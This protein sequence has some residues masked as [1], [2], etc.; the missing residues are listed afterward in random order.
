[1][2]YDYG[3]ND[4]KCLS[5]LADHL[6]EE[7]EGLA[8]WGNNKFMHYI[9]EV[10][11]QIKDKLLFIIDD[12]HHDDQSIPPSV[13]TIFICQTLYLEIEKAKRRIYEHRTDINIVTLRELEVIDPSIIPTAAWRYI[14]P[15]IYPIAIPEIQF[16]PEQDLILLALPMQHSPMMPNGLGYLNNA[17]KDTGIKFQIV[18]TN[19]ILYHRYHSSKI[20]DGLDHVITPD[21]YK[22]EE[23]LWHFSSIEEWKKPEVL[24]YFA[25]QIEEIILGLKHA[26]PKMIGVS[27]NLSN[28]SMA[29]IVIG[30]IRK[31]L[32]E[33]VILVGGQACVSPTEGPKLFSDYDYMCIFDS[34]LTLPTLAKALLRGEKPKNMPGV[35]SKYDSPDRVWVDTPVVEDL[36]KNGFPQYDWVKDINIY[37]DYSGTIRIPISLSRGCVWS[38]CRFCRECF[39][40]R[41]R[42]P[43]EVAEEMEWYVK[44]ACHV[45]EFNESDINGDPSILM[46]LCDEIKNRRLKLACIGQLRIDKRSNLAFFERMIEGGFKSLRFGVDGWSKHTLR[47]QNKGY[48]LKTVKKNL[49][50]AR[51]AGLRVAV[52]ILI[53][54]PG[55]TEVDIDETIENIIRLKAYIDSFEFVSLMQLI[56]DSEYYK[57]PEKYN[58]HFRGDKNRIYSRHT[59]AI[60]PDLW[61]S[62]DPYIDENVRI[63]RLKRI[64]A[65]LCDNDIH[66]GPYAMYLNKS[67][68]ESKELMRW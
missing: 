15:S 6:I 55:E 27:L 40:H 51:K 4:K 68:F 29:Q 43:I 62:Q 46:N 56:V 21:G 49:Q 64:H 28:L 11:P 23:D 48:I 13:K 12:D 42:N 52:N 37:R 5:A 53:G 32:P 14:E 45:F 17:L 39:A 57:H 67:I 36:D 26:N 8:F 50:A 16:L 59:S 65:A 24:D 58:I 38:R 44:R 20:L 33:T 66:I 10:A 9:L 61:Y 41:I 19:I 31:E 35:I 2:N 30:K 3:K 47:L 63:H 25:P 18:D 7:T 34:E 1:L 54:V 22:I 60:P